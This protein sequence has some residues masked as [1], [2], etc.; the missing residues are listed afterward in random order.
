MSHCRTRPASYRS[1]ASLE[2]FCPFSVCWT[3]MRLPGAAM[4]QAIPL[5]RL[6]HLSTRA[7]ARPDRQRRPPLRFCALRMRCG[8][9]RWRMGRMLFTCASRAAHV[10]RLNGRARIS[11]HHWLGGWDDRCNRFIATRRVRHIKRLR[12]S[13]SPV[14]HRSCTVVCFSRGVP[15]PIRTLRGLARPS[16]PSLARS[17]NAPG[18]FISALRRFAPASGGR[19]F[20]IARA[21]VPVRSNA[22][23]D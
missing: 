19:S 12:I 8:E 22:R 17:G 10:R 11:T 9:A 4:L 14:R 6:R 2:V 7:I 13:H 1:G 3:A 5:R 21:H 16:G 23:P 18:V 15:L 20:L